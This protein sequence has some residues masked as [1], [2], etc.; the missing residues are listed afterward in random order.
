MTTSVTSFGCL[1]C[2]L[3]ANFMHWSGV[4][5]IGFEQGNAGQVGIMIT[6]K[7]DS[8]QV[9]LKFLPFK[10]KA[11]KSFWAKKLIKKF[12]WCIYHYFIYV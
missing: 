9:M 2:K 1:Y 5:I 10:K 11:S 6:K 4:S 12:V 3:Q 8:A 7:D